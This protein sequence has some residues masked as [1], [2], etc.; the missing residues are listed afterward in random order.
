MDKSNILH[1]IDTLDMGGA[2]KLLTGT[3]NGLPE[4]NHHIICLC[5][6]GSLV[7]EL[8][9]DC[10]VV[11]LNF[12]SKLD[13]W[14]CVKQLRRYIR[15]NNISIVH[16]HLVMS[17]MIARLACPKDT[18][19]FSTLH[20]LLGQRCFRRGQRF[21]R[22]LERLIYRKRHHIIAVSKEVANDYHNAIG[23]KG[24]Y[25]VLPNF[26]EDKFF[27]DDYK[28]MSF[29]GR[30]RM[31]TVGSLKPAK[32]HRYLAE[33]F[34]H[35]P[36][37]VSLDIY[38]DGPLRTEMEEQ[39]E[40][41]QLNIKLCGMRNDV[42]EVLPQYDAFVMSSVFEGQPVAL[43]E[44]MA[45]GMPSILSDIST[46]REAAGDTGI[47]CDLNNVADFVEKVKAIAN[48][49]VDL[50]VYA[51]GAFERVQQM[52][53]KDR[54]MQELTRLYMSSLPVAPNRVEQPVPV[55]WL[56]QGQLQANPQLG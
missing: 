18:P 16:S 7:K 14:R 6:T 33:A 43:L 56:P 5:G 1:V 40:K 46:L 52:A 13:T 11:T 4:F 21:Q 3:V 22:F 53:R 39:I 49:E 12:R 20:S 10:K 47:F 30:F 48:H 26:V 25:H 35:L 2:E 55:Q 15:D 38:G 51:K 42:H 23:I 32:N 17:T 45:C 50:D 54:Y 44:A 31:V 37:G 8:P 24:G 34:R 9:A 29:N 19:L 28:R 41:Y 27:K 36:K